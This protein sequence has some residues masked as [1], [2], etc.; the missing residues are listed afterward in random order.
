[1]DDLWFYEG[2]LEKRFQEPGQGNGS[3]AVEEGTHRGG[4]Q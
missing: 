1:M 3:E 4:C 2:N